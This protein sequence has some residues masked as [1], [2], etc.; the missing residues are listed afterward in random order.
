M[1]VL[2][3]T[4][5]PTTGGIARSQGAMVESLE[6]VGVSC[7]CFFWRPGPELGRFGAICP[8]YVGDQIELSALA[9]EGGFDV[10]HLTTH[11]L[12]M[13][14]L[15][16]LARGGYRGG[17][18]VRSHG[19]FAGL[20][21]SRNT[22]LLT[23]VSRWM[24][25]EIRPFCDLEPL[26]VPNGVDLKLFTPEGE[27]PPSERPVVA[28]AGR[29]RDWEKNFGAALPVM[30]EPALEGWELWVADADAV[31]D[32]EALARE[33]DRPVRVYPRLSPEE[34]AA[35]YRRVARG[36]GVVLSTSRYEAAGRVLMEATA[37]GCPVVAPRIGGIP[38]YLGEE[39]WGIVYPPEAAPGE[40]AT[41]IV[42]LAGGKER[43]RCLAQAAAELPARFDVRQIARQWVRLYDQAAARPVAPRPGDVDR[44]ATR[45]W[46]L[47]EGRREHAFVPLER[48]RHQVLGVPRWV[49]REMVALAAAAWLAKVRHREGEWFASS[50]KLW[51]HLGQA[52]ECYRE[53][54]GKQS[55]VVR[56]HRV[57]HLWK[58]VGASSGDQRA[59]TVSV[60]IPVHN[61]AGL[62]AGALESVLA[63]TH[64]PAEIIVVDDGS[65]D[66]LERA[67]ARYRDEVTLLRNP[68]PR[69]ASAAR[70]Q[71]LRAARGDWVAFL[72]H[73]DEW[74]PGHLKG[75][76]AAGAGRPEVGLVYGDA[77]VF[78][79]EQRESRLGL[80]EPGRQPP[81]G[82]VFREL[83]VGANFALPSAAAVRREAAL[84]VGG[85]DE[86]L[87]MA[88]DRDLWLRLAARWEVEFAPGA[89]ARYRRRPG[90]ASHNIKRALA[91]QYRVFAGAARYAPGEYRAVERRVR[92]RLAAICAE[93][94]RL[95]LADDDLPEARRWLW[96]GL[97][98]PGKRIRA[99]AYLAATLLPRP[100]REGLRHLRR[101]AAGGLAR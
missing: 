23:A 67:L 25:E 51:R 49:L 29:S 88:E 9:R 72:D 55:Q 57:R 82:R 76:L 16:A 30:R 78:G 97:S 61:G 39:R 60:V 8:V 1:R 79:E 36:G 42:S 6:K 37:C 7:T 93:L 46:F 100:A 4:T 71:G 24:A 28:W 81:R 59:E 41:A 65:T 38:E 63:Q 101:R 89:Q 83:L 14:T 56:Q 34:M 87:T 73:D 45:R 13:G 40:I 98:Y 2:L 32:E 91:N 70:N 35:F 48:G 74:R 27:E 26:V 96:R 99:L 17:V 53:W 94:G 64:P 69:G 66:D 3:V 77:E 85:F 58:Q 80:D 21:C 47:R 52:I 62:I 15:E 5:H 54:R 22:S 90:S 33:C 95:H 18:V 20:V 50:A 10:V 31:L 84:A 75:L 12:Q 44:R 68:E 92:R 86:G 11:C 19:G 43:A